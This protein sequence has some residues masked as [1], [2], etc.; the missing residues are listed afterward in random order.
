MAETKEKTFM[1]ITN[2]DIYE[3]ILSVEEK[4]EATHDQACKTNGRVCRYLI[5]LFS[6][7][8]H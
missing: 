3:K 5:F 8:F 6:P 7:I 1:R 2:K 4:V